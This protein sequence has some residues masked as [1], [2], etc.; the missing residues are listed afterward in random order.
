[1]NALTSSFGRA[2]TFNLKA[3]ASDLRL[4]GYF[5][6]APIDIDRIASE[7]EL[8]AAVQQVEATGAAAAEIAGSEFSLQAGSSLTAPTAE[9]GLVDPAALT[10]GLAVTASALPWL[11]GQH[12]WRVGFLGQVFEFGGGF[13]GGEFF[14]GFVGHQA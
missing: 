13:L 5:S 2:F 14:D 4:D 10:V 3:P 7:F 9:L 6:M 1:M 8:H 11:I 12:G